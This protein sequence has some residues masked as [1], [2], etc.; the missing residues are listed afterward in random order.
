M[1]AIK[2]S[3]PI[4][5]K[6]KLL[7]KHKQMNKKCILVAWDFTSH[8]QNS[9]SHALFYS[10]LTDQ[11]V[12][13]L[14]IVKKE[15]MRTEIEIRLNKEAQKILSETGVKVQTMVQVNNITDGLIKAAIDTKA[16]MIIGSLPGFKGLQKYI[17]RYVINAIMGSVIPSTIVQAP[18]S[19]T[20]ELKVICPIDCKRQSKE[21]L[22][23]VQLLAQNPKVKIQLVYPS[24]SCS[25]QSLFTKCNI[26][27][28]KNYL[29]RFNIK[30]E[31]KTLPCKKF[32]EKTLEHAENENADLILHLSQKESKWRNFFFSSNNYKFV[33][34][35]KKIPVM[36]IRPDDS[37][38]KTSGFN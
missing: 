21:L 14:H 8:A 28:S 1:C 34:N 17:G 2:S 18:K 15:V 11:E 36:S 29:S 10:E 25:I 12:C 19:D 35:D 32:K 27:F 24:Y 13:L 30:F 26:N 5:E 22:A 9:L 37:M 20:N 38:Y 31:E 33:T 6:Q 4:K 7:L 23:M 16:S 3:S